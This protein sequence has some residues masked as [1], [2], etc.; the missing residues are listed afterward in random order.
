MVRQ[1]I[2]HRSTSAEQALIR[3]VLFLRTVSSDRDVRAVLA[4]TGFTRADADEGWKLLRAACAVDEVDGKRA[5]SESPR[6]DA[7]AELG[8]FAR[9]MMPR[10]RA[11]L[12]R[13]HPAQHEFLF[14]GLPAGPRQ[15]VVAVAMFVE[16]CDALERSP[17]RRR[18]RKDDHAALAVLAK[19]GLTRAVLDDARRHVEIATTTSAPIVAAHARDREALDR[20][21]AWLRDW[22]DCARTVIVRR[23]WLIRLGIGRRRPKGRARAKSTAEG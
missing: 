16:R 4:S 5:A 20:L 9:T 10:A 7:E 14:D 13:L 23:D 11:A 21:H 2:E 19:R 15:V 6:A 17:K 1:V 18:T 22:S 8:A 3:T 12:R